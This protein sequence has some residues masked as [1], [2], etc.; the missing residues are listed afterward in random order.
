[1]WS[2]LLCTDVRSFVNV[3]KTSEKANWIIRLDDI[4]VLDLTN[5]KK[6]M[7]S[8]LKKFFLYKEIK[9]FFKFGNK[10]KRIANLAYSTRLSFICYKL[11]LILS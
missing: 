2:I 10:I 3:T 4:L 5:I 7:I 8:I 6:K 9:K 1:M 11:A